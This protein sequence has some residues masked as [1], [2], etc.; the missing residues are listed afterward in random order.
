MSAFL[1]PRTAEKICRVNRLLARRSERESERKREREEVGCHHTENLLQSIH[2]S[3]PTHARLLPPP[4]LLLLALLVRKK[5]YGIR[6][7]HPRS[8][9]QHASLHFF[10][11]CFFP[12]FS[13]SSSPSPFILFYIFS[14]VRSFPFF[15]FLPKS[16]FSVLLCV[17]HGVWWSEPFFGAIS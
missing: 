2:K 7:P 17:L 15:C 1:G 4:P 8:S 11:T 5:W 16:L 9:S 13:S 12:T 6:Q 10:L 14:S 3:S